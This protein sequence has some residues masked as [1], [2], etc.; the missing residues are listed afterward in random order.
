MKPSA[1]HIIEEL[2]NT[3][4]AGKSE[5][6]RFMLRE[7]LR[8]LVRVARAEQLLEIRQDAA[9]L[10]R[11]LTEGAEA[12]QAKIDCLVRAAESDGH[13]G[14]LAF[15]ERPAARTRRPHRTDRA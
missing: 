14:Q 12:R 2:V 8:H 7:T 11:S 13:Q 9:R 10:T 6:E 5:R 4:H 3:V 15:D 1:D